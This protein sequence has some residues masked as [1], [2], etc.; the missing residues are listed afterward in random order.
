MI[1]AAQPR[2]VADVDALAV[3]DLAVRRRHVGDR[4]VRLVGRPRRGQPAAWLVLADEHVDEGVAE[5]LTGEVGEQDR[6]HVVAPRQQHGGTGV[7]DDDRVR[8]G[9]GDGADEVVLAAG[10]GERRAV[11]ALRLDAGVRADDDDGDVAR[12][13]QLGGLVGSARRGRTL[14]GSSAER[15]RQGVAPAGRPD[16]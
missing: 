3:D 12:R 10:Q 2:P 1:A 4:D 16:R 8:V 13:R 7:D 5:V 14:S 11:V 6:R 9:R 15:E